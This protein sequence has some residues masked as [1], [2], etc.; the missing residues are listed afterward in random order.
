MSTEREKRNVSTATVM[1][2][3]REEEC[4][5]SQCDE[6]QREKRNVSTATVMHREREKRNV[7]TATVM[8]REGEECSYLRLPPASS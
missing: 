2:R 3:E 4:K 8:H 5:H 6:E 1:H 7:S